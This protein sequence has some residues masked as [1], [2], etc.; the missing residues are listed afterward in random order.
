MVS[1][2]AGQNIDNHSVLDTNVISKV[3]Y[4]RIARNLL[5]MYGHQ[6]KTD[7]NVSISKN[8]LENIDI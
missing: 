7:N 6:K 3:S 5:P 4:A 2:S 1:T 8:R